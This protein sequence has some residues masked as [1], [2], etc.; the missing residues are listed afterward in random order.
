[1]RKIPQTKIGK[2]MRFMKMFSMLTVHLWINLRIA[3]Q[4]HIYAARQKAGMRIFAAGVAF[5]AGPPGEG[6][7]T[8]HNQIS[9]Q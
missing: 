2:V 6:T 7:I 1:M 9:L 4:L 8:F 5:L 3:M